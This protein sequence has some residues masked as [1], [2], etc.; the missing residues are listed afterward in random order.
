MAAAKDQPLRTPPPESRSRNQLEPSVSNED[1]VGDCLTSGSGLPSGA[2]APTTPAAH[3]TPMFDDFA[4]DGYTPL[5]RLTMF[6]VLENLALPQ[7]LESLQNTFQENAERL[8][9]R[10]AELASKAAKQKDNIVGEWKKRVPQSE[11]QLDQYR[12]RIR[13]SVDRLNRRWND[14]KNVTVKEKISFVTAIMNILISGYLIGGRPEYFHYWYT[15]Q[16]MSVS[17]SIHVKIG[18][19]LTFDNRYFM[20]IRW[21]NYHKI[22]FHYFLADLCYYVNFLLILSIWFFPQSKRLFISV[23]CLA[24]GNNAVAI[25]MWRNSLV[26]HSFDKVNS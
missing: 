16:L 5:D 24:F 13:N 14:S 12:R 7:R 10:R 4:K 18:R 1:I 17:S 15:A 20:P 26:L 22:G 8:R 23:Y 9:R 6:D 19:S 3:S 2:T 21:Y 11:E 25:V